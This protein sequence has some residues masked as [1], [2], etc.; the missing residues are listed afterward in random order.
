VFE[1]IQDVHSNATTIGVA[2]GRQ[3]RHAPSIFRKYSHFE[4]WEAFFQTK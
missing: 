3:R 2:R 1:S 4:L